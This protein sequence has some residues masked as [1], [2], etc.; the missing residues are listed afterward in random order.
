MIRRWMLAVVMLSAMMNQVCAQEPADP[1]DAVK[2][3]LV[4]AY[5]ILTNEGTLDGFGHISAR[6]RKDPDIFYM[7]RAMP[8]SLVT[9]EDV[10]ALRVSDSQPID[11]RGRKVNGERYIHGEIYKARP[12]V[13]AVVH[14]HSQSVIPLSLTHIP[15]RP[16]IAQAG[17]LPLE[18]PNFEIRDA[19]GKDGRG[20]QVTDERRGA[21]LAKALGKA[22]AILMRGHGDTVVGHSIKQAVVFAVYVDADARM[23]TQ[24]ILLSKNIVPMNASE[25]FGE[26]AFDINRPWE[27]MLA[28]TMT[29]EE[30]ARVDHAQFGLEQTQRKQ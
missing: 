23:Q 28:K 8:P 3:Q 12:D 2:D 10:L 4:Q 19:R 27:Y 20:M 5:L 11:P 15:L 9:R 24:A 13:M 21:A 7:P 17:F 25:Q 16:V 22:P 6:S 18:T 30:K 14:S 29:P 26:D 1:D